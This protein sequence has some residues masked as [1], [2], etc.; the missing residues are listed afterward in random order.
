MKKRTYTVKNKRS[1]SRRSWGGSQPGYRAGKLAEKRR[2]RRR[3]RVLFIIVAGVVLSAALFVAI[4]FMVGGGTDGGS[5]SGGGPY[6][7]IESVLVTVKDDTGVVPLVLLLAVD[8]GGAFRVASIPGR[9]VVEV[10]DKGFE[11]L[12]EAAAAGNR[13]AV[14]QA[15]ADL[16]QYPV[17]YHAE[18]DYG[19]LL[20]AAE[21]VGTFDINLREPAT[22]TVG[23]ALVSLVAGANTVPSDQAVSWLAA[24]ADDSDAGPE[25][26]AAFFQGLRDAFLARSDSDRKAFADQLYKRVE[27]DLG[28]EQF[29]AMFLGATSSDGQ[30]TVTPVPARLKGTGADWYL[31]PVAGD[32]ETV[33]GPG[34]QSQF[35]LE[36]RN[37]TET[38][39]VVEAAAEKLAPLGIEMTLTPETSGVNFD[40]TQIRYGSDAARTGN[41]IRDLLGAGTLIKDDYLE[42]NEI[43]VIIGLDLAAERGLR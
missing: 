7:G 35:T 9:T 34:R 6:G 27:T 21:Q 31:E 23:D 17:Q 30:F 39:D 14:D 32:A 29:V 10:P 20:L 5:G 33:L 16:L 42:N 8:E 1:R 18:L 13:E 11:S 24:A 26:Q 40:F 19:T 25:V 4:F 3:R 38:V 12:G 37:G 15:V 2:E 36:I 41:D 43:I 28:E 22:L